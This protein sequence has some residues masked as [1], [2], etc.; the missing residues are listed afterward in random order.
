MKKKLNK[1]RLIS[2]FLSI[3]M[4]CTL[5]LSFPSASAATYS[6]NTGKRD[7]VCSS[8]STKAKSYYTGSYVYD[9]L[10]KKSASS[11]KSSLKTLM[12]NTHTK[13]TT[14]ENLKTYT[15]YSDATAGSS[16][17][18]TLFYTSNSVSNKWNSNVWNREHVWPQSLG[19]FTTSNCGSDMHHLRPADSKINSTRCNLPYGNVLSK[20]SYKTAKTSSGSIGGYYTSTYFEP[21]ANVKGDIARILLYNYVRWGESNLT[22]VI[23]SVD[24][25]LSWCKSD[26][27][28]TWEMGRNDVVQGIQGNRNVFIDYPEYSWLI[29]GKSVPSGMTT[30]SGKS[31]R[32]SSSSSGSSSSSSS[33]SSSSGNSTVTTSG[34]TYTLVTSAPSNWSGNYVLVGKSG[35]TTYV[36]DA[37]GSYKSTNIGTKSAAKTLSA[38]GIKASGNKLTNVA[39]K[40]VYTIG[41]T[42]SYYYLKMKGSTNY[43]TYQQNNLTTS[44]SKT[45][46][47]SQ[48]S[49]SLSSGVAKIKSRSA[50]T[51]NLA[52]NASSKL[53]RCYSSSNNYKL[54]LYKAN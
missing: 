3:V 10:S 30:P 32:S 51:Y 43:L 42:G 6:Y 13:K 45:A 37:S 19:T 41:K 23:Q 52:F 44:T 16:S 12:T 46:T 38:A 49:I 15:K 47:A 17:K 5:L 9:T 40:Y 26:P 7:V 4:V 29:F 25:L 35:T 34:K 53:F 33:G 11:I 27:V 28:D 22:D 50:S 1:N 48:W 20:G 14:Y 24:V 54:Y 21:K 31:S 36:L 39:D 8:L 18:M 2:V